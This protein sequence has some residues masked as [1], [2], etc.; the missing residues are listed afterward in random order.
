MKPINLLDVTDYVRRHGLRLLLWGLGFALAGYLVSFLIPPTYRA[1]AVILPPEED[2]L[3]SSISLTRRSLGGLG[4]LGRIGSYFTEADIALAI[5]RSRTVAEMV[6]QKFE[7]QKLYRSKDFP[8]AVDRLRELVRVRIASDGTI[9]VTVDDR[10]AERSAN[11]ANQFLAELDRENQKFRSATARRTREFLERRVAETDS[12]LRVAERL[13]AA[14][15]SRKGALLVSPELRVSLDGA[16]SLM[17]QK[18]TA[19]TELELLKQY[20]SARSEEVKRLEARVA[21]LRRQVGNVPAMQVGGAE[22]LRDIGTRQEVLSILVPQL[23]QARIR[24]AMDTPTIQVLDPA[25]P[26]T[27]R[28]WP[29]RAWIAAFGFIVGIIVFAAELP[30]QAGR[31]AGRR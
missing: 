20:A 2:E 26:P 3:S 11:M 17:A 28:A 27:R 10:S 25:Q 6:T 30:A 5:L 24:E 4:G 13:A 29:R 19:E 22:L 15:Q 31:L 23:E 7:L 14:Y 8:T 9:S 21:E 18:I 16:S 1:S 12:S